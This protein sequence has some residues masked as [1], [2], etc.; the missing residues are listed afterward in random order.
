MHF[1]LKLYQRFIKQPLGSYIGP[2]TVNITNGFICC[3][4]NV[5]TLVTLSSPGWRLL[6]QEFRATG[7]FT[8][9]SS[10]CAWDD[11]TV[12]EEPNHHTVLYNRKSPLAE[13][14]SG[15]SA[16]CLDWLG[17]M[18][19]GETEKRNTERLGTNWEQTKVLQSVVKDPT[20]I[21]RNGLLKITQDSTIISECRPQHVRSAP[22]VRNV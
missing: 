6:C 2:Q 17:V 7:Q 12:L 15:R 16:I 18:G 3:T 1:I 19:G 13:P 14:G 9:Q 8:V 5:V 22:N 10:Q 11:C 21:N 20:A 4:I